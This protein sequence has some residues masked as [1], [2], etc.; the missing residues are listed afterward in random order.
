ML[1]RCFAECSQTGTHSNFYTIFSK[2]NHWQGGLDECT[3]RFGE[4]QTPWAPKTISGYHKWSRLFTMNHFCCA[5][6]IE[7]L[8]RVRTDLIGGGDN[9]M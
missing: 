7:S 2:E 4:T 1:F 8:E 3:N 6:G 9:G 5:T